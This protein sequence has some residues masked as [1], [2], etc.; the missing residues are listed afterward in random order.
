MTVEM[1]LPYLP[2]FCKTL[3]SSGTPAWQPAEAAWCTLR[4]PSPAHLRQLLQTACPTSLYPSD[5]RPL[6]GVTHTAPP[7]QHATR[8]CD[9]NAC[10]WRARSL[11]WRQ[12]ALAQ[13][14]AALPPAALAAL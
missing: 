5:R 9:T 4:S 14:R 2:Q 7:T 8:Q 11:A 10:N 6:L 13:L 12:Q 1:M 3:H